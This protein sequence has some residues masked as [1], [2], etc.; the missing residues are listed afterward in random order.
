MIIHELSYQQHQ[1][2]RDKHEIIIHCNLF[3]DNSL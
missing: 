1:T 2:Q 3:D